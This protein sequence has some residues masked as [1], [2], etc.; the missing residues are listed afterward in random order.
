MPVVPL[1]ERQHAHDKDTGD[2]AGAAVD[3][4]EMSH[5]GRL[6]SGTGRQSQ[7]RPRIGHNARARYY[8]A[9]VARRRLAPGSS[10]A[11]ASES[12]PGHP[13]V[14]GMPLDMR[15][16]PVPERSTTAVTNIRTVEVEYPVSRVRRFVNALPAR[17]RNSAP[18]RAH[19]H[20][21]SAAH[22]TTMTTLVAALVGSVKS[23]G[24]RQR[25]LAGPTRP[26]TPRATE[27][28]TIAAVAPFT[29]LSTS[30]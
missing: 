10:G 19:T 1:E 13:G 8:R 23:K 25:G 15:N 3:P 16:A 5:S 27:V 14:G 7:Q 11:D 24:R 22:A 29:N 18:S 6:V 9:R 17:P 21:S 30:S 2:G 26:M 4:E 28:T 20:Q 12:A